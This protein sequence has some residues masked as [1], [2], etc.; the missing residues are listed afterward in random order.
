MYVCTHACSHT[1]MRTCVQSYIHAYQHVWTHV[2]KV[3][4][5]HRPTYIIAGI[6]LYKFLLAEFTY[7]SVE[8]KKTFPKKPKPPL[9]RVIAS[10]AAGDGMRLTRKGGKG[11]DWAEGEKDPYAPTDKSKSQSLW[12]EGRH[13]R[14]LKKKM[15][16]WM[17]LSI[18]WTKRTHKPVLQAIHKDF[19]HEERSTPSTA[20][21]PP[22]LWI[23]G[24][25]ESLEF[26][27]TNIQRQSQRLPYTVKC[28]APK[29]RF[30]H[31]H[32]QNYL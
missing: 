21:Q 10:N 27:F 31:I 12:L 7:D 8:Y 28:W 30:I 15:N 5:T 2:H 13:T 17:H 4:V 19:D 16:E 22:C 14:T 6:R 9:Q 11:S 32:I 1:H 29:L 26:Y 25:P 24:R 3:K 18:N 20:S 23:K